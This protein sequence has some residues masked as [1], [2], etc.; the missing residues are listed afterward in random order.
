MEFMIFTKLIH[1]SEV[2]AIMKWRLLFAQKLRGSGW[3]Q[4]NLWASEKTNHDRSFEMTKAG[5][6][7]AWAYTPRV[8]NTRPRPRQRLFEKDLFRNH[9]LR[10]VSFSMAMEGITMP[11]VGC[12]VR[13]SLCFG[14]SSC[15]HVLPDFK[16]EFWYSE[17]APGKRYSPGGTL[18]RSA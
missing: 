9:G 2:I 10:L 13:N 17:F 8:G 15:L 7:Q 18:S 16:V 5:L 11:I 4:R 3:S 14:V 1:G 12:K 6:V